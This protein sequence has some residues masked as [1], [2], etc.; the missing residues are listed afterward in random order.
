MQWPDTN[1]A[2]LP[3][4]GEDTYIGWHHYEIDWTPEAIN[5][6]VDGIVKRTLTK[7]STWNGTANRYEYPQT[8]S[9]MQLSLWPAGRASNAQGTIDWAGGQID[10]NAADIRDQ[11]YYSATFA[12]ITMQCYEPPAGSGDGHLSYAYVEKTGLE[13]SV[14]VTNNSTV[15]PD[16][17]HTGLNMGTGNSSTGV[18]ASEG[19]S[20]TTLTASTAASTEF[21]QHEN[22]APGQLPR[23]VWLVAGVLLVAMIIS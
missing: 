22:N 23:S 3:I 18:G 4:T 8:P 1:G 19:S 17:G 6:S 10:W 9:R 11:G 2:K 15:L 14:R 12:N 16:M 7:K 13:S 21:V 20:P 5:W